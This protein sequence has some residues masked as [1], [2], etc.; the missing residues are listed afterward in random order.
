MVI[1]NLIGGLGNQMFQYAAG[2]ALSLEH[3]VDLRLDISEFANYELHQGFELERV[4]N[5]KTEIATEA[6]VRKI[7]GWQFSSGLRRIMLRP[8]VAPLRRTG[9]VVEPHY[10][11][12]SGIGKTPR[13]CYLVG[14][15]QSEKYFQD[16]AP[17]IR[18]DFTFKS[19]LISRNADIAEQMSQ[20][21]A[22]S[23][24]VR[25]GDY[26]NNPNTTAT[27]GLCSLAYYQG[28]I[29]YIAERVE[30]P[31]FFIFSDDVVWVKENLKMNFPCQYVDHNREA[32]SYNDM[33]LMSLCQH[34]II[35]NSSFSWW[36]AWLNQSPEKIVIAP[37]RW[38]NQSSNDTRDL[39][40]DSW[41]KL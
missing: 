12:W 6:D 30:Q 9:F 5:C 29:Q 13:D 22:I 10:R 34:H 15:W 38:F 40:P 8:S 11:Y 16:V 33:R 14:Y 26:A 23:L 2:K 7:L 32:E 21:S 39:L 35:A 1:S 28:A 25:R 27:H 4:F 19:P 24:H 41:V 18:A 20:V 31:V 36:G 17:V 3:G 37:E